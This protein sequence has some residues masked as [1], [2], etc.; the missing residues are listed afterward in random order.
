MF[1][2]LSGVVL[3]MAYRRRAERGVRQEVLVPVWR[4][5]RK[6][7]LTA[8]AVTVAAWLTQFLP[9]VDARVLTTWAETDADGRAVRYDLY[10]GAAYG[11][12]WPPPGHLL[13][14]LLFL[15]IGPSQF[16]VMGLYVVLLAGA[17]AVLA[18]LKR[19]R[20]RVVLGGSLAL[21]GLY[22]LSPQQVLP[23]A[24]ENP[25]PLLAWQL[26]FVLGMLAGWYRAE[27][28]AFTRTAA[29]RA[30]VAGCAV[31]FLAAMFFTSNNPWKPFVAG[32]PAV[33][34]S[35]IPEQTFTSL[36]TSFFER[37]PLDPGRVLVVVVTLVTLY[38]ALTA[39][40]G[41][42][43]RVVV[44]VLAPLGQATLYVF[45]LQVFFVLLVANI[46]LPSSTPALWGTLV[47]T[48]VLAVLWLM[49]R[50]RVLFRLIPR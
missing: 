45:V 20:W 40:W 8:L 26:L 50:H 27:L 25:F 41:P 29:G 36:Y 35:L 6:L 23:T 14:D 10:G 37:T 38:A 16:N 33:R 2:T 24:F 11:L 4:R 9:G 7:Y 39:F 12:P 22:Q 34:L 49:V 32:S 42:L 18:L 17:P 43:S 28:L 13:G 46:E 1:V 31:L 44:P 21:Y 5:A 3:A 15:R 19:D 47:H 48:G 30:C